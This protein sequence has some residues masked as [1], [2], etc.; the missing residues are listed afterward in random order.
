M[1]PNNLLVKRVRKEQTEIEFDRL[2]ADV[3][4]WCAHR[5][6]EDQLRQY[7]TQLSAIK[8]LISGA[9]EHLQTELN[10]IDL[11]RPQGDFYAECQRFDLLVVWLN[12]VWTFYKDKFDQRDDGK[13]RP[14]LLAADEVV[15][16][17]YQQV[18]RRADFFGAPIRQGPAPLPFVEASYSPESFPSELVPYDLRPSETGFL[19]ALMNR[20]PIPLVSLP[21]SC[22]RAPWW[23]VYVGHEVGHHIQYAL[24]DKGGFVKKFQTVVENA[25]KTKDG[26]PDDVERWGRWGKEI[27]ADVF[28]VLTMGQ[29]AVWAMVE[30]ETQKPDAMLTRRQQYPSPVIRLY[31]LAHTANSLKLD[32]TAA[33][34]G[35][36]VEKMIAGNEQAERDFSFVPEVVKTAL[37]MEPA[38]NVTLEKLVDFDQADFQ[39]RGNV[40]GWSAALRGPN[41]AAS[42]I[43]DLRYA[44]LIT[45]ATLAAWAEVA[46]EGEVKRK[47]SRTDLATKALRLIVES[48]EP[49]DRLELAA[50]VDSTDFGVELAR[51]LMTAN[52]QQLQP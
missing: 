3:E 30:F 35:L 13:L 52:Q 12:K 21:Q 24:A 17:C 23:L 38:P 7:K 36:D 48:R 28:S 42:A 22:V 50:A 40:Q 5:D 8:K 9:A 34:R 6:K 51:Q 16:S 31:L 27:F 1:E 37:A 10:K 41:P 14:L 15:W 20:L 25:V 47:E 2:K 45:S 26:N 18:F 4:S 29:W 46:L 49:G 43:A 44:R 32:G 39:P 33:L 19:Q 11:T